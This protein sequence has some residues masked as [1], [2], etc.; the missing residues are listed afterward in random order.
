MLAVTGRDQHH[1][2]MAQRDSAAANTTSLWGTH[3]NLPD[4]KEISLV[5][6][7]GPRRKKLPF[8]DLQ[9]EGEKIEGEGTR[10]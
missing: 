5:R 4:S 10:K 1:P 6:P 8:K 3:V 7:M 2:H 9:R